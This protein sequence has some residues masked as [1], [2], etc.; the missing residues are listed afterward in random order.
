M[1]SIRQNGD[2][3]EVVDPQGVVVAS[4]TAAP[5]AL[6]ALSNAVL[7]VGGPT[8]LAEAD[9]LLPEAWEDADGIAFSEETGDGRDFTS[10]AWTFRDPA[11][12]LLPLMLQTE[13]EVGHFGAQLAGFLETVRVDGTTPRASGRF[14][15]S[16]AGR[17]FRDLLLGGR[18]F[19]V[20]VD[21][22][23][24]AAEWECLEEDEEGWC[25]EETVRFLEYEIIG[26]TGTPFPAFARAAIRLA[27][28][29]AEETDEET[30]EVEEEATITPLPLPA[31]SIPARP[32]A[33][34]FSMP[35]PEVGS[36]LLVEQ[37][38]GGL[39]CPLTITDDGRVFGHLARWGQNH[40]GY[41]ASARVTAPRS[42]AAYAHFHVGQVV[43]A[44][45]TRVATGTLTA[46]CDHAATRLRAAEAADH[47]AHNGVAWADVRVSDGDLGAWTCGALRPDVT[48]AQVRVLRAG[49]LSGDWRDLGLGLELI[50]GLAVNVPGFP[51]AREALAASGLETMPEVRTRG[52]EADHRQVSLVAAGLV[53]R[54]VECQ[55]AALAA[56]GGRRVEEPGP[57]REVETLLRS[58]LDRLGVIELRT[59]HLRTPARDDVARRLRA[60][61]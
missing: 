1:W 17:A 38:D 10:C 42:N 49:A 55:R 24:V 41:P 6:A 44:D 50:G 16:D 59:R 27:G 57:S 8:A 48:E 53:T 28:E 5:L 20:S 12:S 37:P 58:V 60:T 34:W 32:P 52:A 29:T 47:Y 19:G 25:V 35:E 22:G 23:H 45:G 33:D 18:V 4:E 11:V 61:R 30:P 46:G 15:D 2:Q 39:A 7:A 21:A 43:C 3:W 26:L 40:V 9:G 36:D 56:A 51:I 13:T 54:C 31:L 14:Y